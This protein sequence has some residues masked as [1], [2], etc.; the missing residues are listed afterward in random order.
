M[1]EGSKIICMVILTVAALEDVRSQSVHSILLLAGNVSAILYQVLFRA[2]NSISIAGGI[3]IGLLFVLVSKVTEEKLGYG[4]SI[5]ILG[6][7]IYLGFWKLL[8]VL[9]GVFFLLTIGAGVCLVFKK[10]DRRCTV[11][12]YPF[13]TVGYLLW[14][15]G[16]MIN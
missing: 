13:L 14:M 7:G 11:P 10:M 15:A 3:A 9:C 5:G 6:M 2:E 1:T 8:E 4:D 16:G 12:F